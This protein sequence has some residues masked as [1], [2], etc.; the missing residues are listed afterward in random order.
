MEETSI[1]ENYTEAYRLF[2]LIAWI[3]SCNDHGKVWRY[4][5][6][7]FQQISKIFCHQSMK[8]HNEDNEIFGIKLRLYWSE[9]CDVSII[10]S[11]CIVSMRMAHSVHT[12]HLTI[13]GIAHRPTQSK[14]LFDINKLWLKSMIFMIIH[15]LI[16]GWIKLFKAF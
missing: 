7:Y 11:L 10:I 16:V 15:M 9:D 4:R 8:Y 3:S 6:S 14:V 12:D 5:Y 13:E 1:H 2:D